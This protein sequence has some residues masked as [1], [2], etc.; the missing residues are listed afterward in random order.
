[1]HGCFSPCLIYGVAENK[2]DYVIDQEILDK[3]KMDKYADDV[4]R[5]YACGF[6]YGVEV[7]F[8]E[9]ITETFPDKELVD[10]FV[11]DFKTETATFHLG[12]RGDYLIEHVT[13]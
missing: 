4:I 11:Q 5:N 9:M 10:K 2:E 1:M 13:Y 7:N 3:Y 12:I 8:N 6:I